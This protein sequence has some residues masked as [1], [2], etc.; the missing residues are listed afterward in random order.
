[1]GK[2]LGSPPE[3]NRRATLA[4]REPACKFKS[5]EVASVSEGEL[6]HE[7]TVTWI[8]AR[9]GLGTVSVRRVKTRASS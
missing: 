8:T 1:M 3:V 5:E 6:S 9:H 7:A 2:V 4:H